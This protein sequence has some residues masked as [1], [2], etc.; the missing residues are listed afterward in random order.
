MSSVRPARVVLLRRLVVLATILVL[1][2][3]A[4]GAAAVS[5]DEKIGS[6]E[7]SVHSTKTVVNTV[8]ASPISVGLPTILPTR[9]SECPS[10]DQTSA[11]PV[12]PQEAP[13]H[14]HQVKYPRLHLRFG[15]LKVRSRPRTRRQRP[16]ETSRPDWGRAA[17]DFRIRLRSRQKIRRHN[18]LSSSKQLRQRPTT[19]TAQLPTIPVIPVFLAATPV[20]APATATGRRHRVTRAAVRNTYSSNLAGITASTSARSG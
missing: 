9:S 6:N 17:P 8:E 19:E 13:E 16:V 11:V 3:P 2:L 10:T 20:T 14:E 15:P 7:V 1:V 12:Q 5:A 18:L 4:L